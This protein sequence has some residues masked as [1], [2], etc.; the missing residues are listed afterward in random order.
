MVKCSLLA[1]QH[2]AKGCY[3]VP[4]GRHWFTE[5]DLAKDLISITRPVRVTA[6]AAL[7]RVRV[8]DEWVDVENVSGG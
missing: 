8:V 5:K 4:K 2:H 1:Q 3:V 7:W 6:L